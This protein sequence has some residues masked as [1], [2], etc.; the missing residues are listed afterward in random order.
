VC[1]DIHSRQ[2]TEGCRGSARDAFA[3]D[4]LIRHFRKLL[5]DYFGPLDNFFDIING[6]ACSDVASRASINV[7]VGNLGLHFYSTVDDDHWDVG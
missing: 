5:T 4:E 3:D 1:I 7:D 6:I 2:N